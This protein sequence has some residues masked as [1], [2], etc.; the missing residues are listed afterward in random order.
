MFVGVISILRSH[1]FSIYSNE[2]FN[3]PLEKYDVEECDG[4]KIEGVKACVE[5][6]ISNDECENWSE[7]YNK[8]CEKGFS[9]KF[10]VEIFLGK[11]EGSEIMF[12][13]CGKTV[14]VV[15][16]Q[17]KSK[18]NDLNFQDTLY[19]MSQSY[20]RCVFNP[21]CFGLPHVDVQKKI[22]ETIHKNYAIS[23]GL[24]V[25]DFSTFFCA[26]LLK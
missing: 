2:P 1:G 11:K 26:Y 23:V 6:I 12:N 19:K 24:P 14:L 5:V 10:P 18:F 21:Y 22:L 20:G 17:K 25:L 9:N 3:E 13:I 4:K 16:V 7:G 8:L 15:C